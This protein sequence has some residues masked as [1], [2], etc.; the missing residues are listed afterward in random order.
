M[1]RFFA[2][3]APNEELSLTNR[4]YFNPRDYNDK[5]KC[6]AVN[7]GGNTYIFRASTDDHI[8]AGKLA[9]GLVQRKWASISVDEPLDIRPYAFNL[10]HDCLGSAV[11]VVDFHNKKTPAG[12][13]LNSDEMAKEFSMEFADTPLTVGQLIMFKFKK[14]LFLVEV[15]KLGT[16]SMDGS[17]N[18]VKVGMLTGNT[19]LAWERQADSKLLLIGRAVSAGG[20]E[21][22]GYQSIINPN[23]DFK[24]MGIGGLDK[25]FSDIFRR[26]FASRM[27]PPAVAEQLGLKHVRGILLYGPPGTGKTLMARQIGKM[28]NAREPKIVNGPSILDKYVGES[29]ANIRKLFADAEEE[30]KRMGPHSA[31]HIIIFDE[32]DAICKTRGSTAGGAGVHDTVVNQLLTKMDGVD[33]LNN[34]L[35]IGMTNR[36]DMIDEALLRP[37]RFEMQM[38]ISLP[39]E[40]GRFQILQIHTAKMYKSGKIAPDI[41]LRELAAKTKNFSGAEIEGLC[42]AAAF[43]AMYQLISRPDGGRG[44]SGKTQLDPNAFDKLVVKRADFMYALENDVKPAFGTAEEELNCYAPRGIMTWGETVSEALNMGKLAV[45][46]VGE[47]DVETYRPLTVLIEGPPKA[48]KTALAVEIA[49]LSGFPFVKICTSHKMIGYTETAKCMAM[50]KIFDDGAKSPMSVVIVDNIEGLIEY[51][52]VG[53]RFSNYIVQA[54]RDLVSQPLKEGRRMLVIG[55]TSCRAELHEQNLTQAFSWHIHISP[56]SRPEHIMAALEEDDRF[57]PEERRQIERSIADGRLDTIAKLLHSHPIA[58]DGHHR[59]FMSPVID[60]RQST[61]QAGYE[62]AGLLKWNHHPMI[63]RMHRAYANLYGEARDAGGEV[64][65]RPNYRT[66]FSLTPTWMEDQLR[67]RISS[68]RE[69]FSPRQ[70]KQFMIGQD[71]SLFNLALFEAAAVGVQRAVAECRYQF[72]HERWNCSQV[73]DEETALF[74][75]I[76]LKGIPQT[77]F[78]YSIINAGIVQSVAEACL[79]QID[80]CPCNTRGRESADPDWQWQGCDH[81]IHYGRRFAHRLLDTM[82]HGA[83][84]RFR[85]NLHNN[86]VGRQLVTRNMERYCRCHGTSGSCTLKT[87][88]R[89]TPRMRK[90]GSMLKQ[91]YDENA[92]YLT[93]DM[94]DT[95]DSSADQRISRS[96]ATELRRLLSNRPTKSGYGLGNEFRYE[97]SPPL[98]SQHP[99]KDAYRRVQNVFS[100]HERTFHIHRDPTSFGMPSPLRYGAWSRINLLL[101]DTRSH[102]SSLGTKLVYYESTSG[103]LFCEPEPNLNILGTRDRICNSTTTGPGSCQ[104]LC[105]GRGFLTHHHYV[106]ESCQCKFI[107]CC[108]V[109]C[110]QCLVLKKVETCV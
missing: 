29:E 38:E 80:N 39:D 96:Q 70:W 61:N 109:E 33:Q 71:N 105:C 47:N 57:T 102:I 65:W 31:L 59:A 83:H 7:T 100:P 8:P 58:L 28:L 1:S 62:P 18:S 78:V 72:R 82:E 67:K 93:P 56:M 94:Y 74:G 37:G 68:Y 66:Q 73:A 91:T 55:T 44:P 69:W 108:R 77:A 51:N 30:E 15:K 63:S 20:G 23:W 106:L 6:I 26:T 49:K 98:L 45:R 53:P 17:G 41:D 14:K 103:K 4:V 43:T 95:L 46:A 54:I 27:F 88:Y 85:M 81:N 101:N 32:I 16:I 60:M 5:L 84:I 86:K 19:V 89:R 52:P 99:S 12:D 22:A 2:T 10:A 97:I 48:G 75:N 76:L 13:P 25:E 90:L 36:R 110:R 24:Q 64:G 3:K 107:W 9:F 79:G 40:D 50:K 34:I 92:V 42:R 35:V 21:G 104:H 11:L 87:C